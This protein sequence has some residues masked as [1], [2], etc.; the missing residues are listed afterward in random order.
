MAKDGHVIFPKMKINI[1]GPLEVKFEL[2]GVNNA[3]TFSGLCSKHDTELFQEIDELPDPSNP[4][5]LFLLAYRAVVREYHVVLQNAVRFQSTLHK[6]VEVGISSPHFPDAFGM[7]ATQAIANFI[8]TRHYKKQFDEAFLQS[9]WASLTHHVKVLDNQRPSVAVNSM[10]SLE[11]IDRDD[12][13]RVFLNVYP[14][15][16]ATIVVFSTTKKDSGRVASFLSRVLHSEQFLFCYLLSKL[17][18][19]NCDN[20]VLAPD[21]W[22]SL[23]VE[24]QTAIERYF[25]ETI[26][27]YVMESE[28]QR[29]Y[30][31]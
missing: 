6:R 18:L 21:F 8:E 3:T 20:I 27:N 23:A 12:T 19:Q 26:E 5:H 13:P 31:F 16:G 2:L 29:L 10:F 17:I 30:L 4:K 22:L 9:N 7:H 28:D 11:Q 24:Q 1:D 14:A 25:V 15:R